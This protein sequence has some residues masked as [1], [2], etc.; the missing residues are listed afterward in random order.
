MFFKKKNDNKVF[1]ISVKFI[2]KDGTE[3][4]CDLDVFPIYSIANIYK[5]DCVLAEYVNYP[6][7]FTSP[8]CLSYDQWKNMDEKC[9]IENETNNKLKFKIE[10]YD[11]KL[12]FVYTGNDENTEKYEGTEAKFKHTVYEKLTGKIGDFILEYPGDRKYK[13]PLMS[14]SLIF[15]YNYENKNQV[16]ADHPNEVN[17]LEAYDV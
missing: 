17:V 10:D 2:E 15:V 8:D 16:T 5:K 7:E 13:I 3:H 4:E 12:N 11:N 14:E 6:I 9:I 1:P